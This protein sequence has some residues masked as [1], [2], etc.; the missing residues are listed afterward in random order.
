MRKRDKILL[1][2]YIAINIAKD[3]FIYKLLKSIYE[4]SDKRLSD[5][6]D[7]DS[8]TIDN[9]VVLNED[10]KDNE[11]TKDE[12]IELIDIDSV[13]NFN[14][15]NFNSEETKYI[16]SNNLQY[17]LKVGDIITIYNGYCD[18]FVVIGKNHD[19]TIGTIDIM[20]I[21]P[22]NDME[23]GYKV[24]NKWM[25]YDNNYETSNIR[26]WINREFISSF[27]DSDIKSSFKTMEVKYYNGD[28]LKVLKDKAK[29]LS[30]NEL[31]PD[32][33]KIYPEFTL[34]HISKLEGNPYS[35]YFGTF[36]HNLNFFFW[37]R[38]KN[39]E[40]TP[41]DNI[42]PTEYR[43]RYTSA[44]NGFAEVVYDEYDKIEI[45]YKEH[46]I[47]HNIINYNDNIRSVLPVL[48]L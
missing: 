40:W 46:G 22:V 8:D 19:F 17:K 16:I 34:Q 6:E 43:V 13:I 11:N 14:K 26:K 31:N 38:S 45:V 18:E 2:G 21:R 33:V 41:G 37:L 23:F 29:I 48:R 4:T 47:I 35:K 42:T 36:D 1:G 25:I 9:V 28:E 15:H 39:L 5:K 12:E 44:D 30:F 7:S 10:T 3:V 20:P 27:I 32:K 24:V